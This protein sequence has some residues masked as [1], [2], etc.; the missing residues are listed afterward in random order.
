MSFNR[1][2][3]SIN[4]LRW[5]IDNRKTLLQ[6]CRI[7]EV[8][9][10]Y[11][12]VCK[13]NDSGKELYPEFLKLLDVFHGKDGVVKTQVDDLLS[14]DIQ[15][16]QD[17]L[18]FTKEQQNK[19]I[20]DARGK[21]HVKSL[22]ALI[23]EAKINL[24]LWNIDRHVVN[25]WDVTNAEGEIYQ[26]WQIKAWLSKREE[27]EAAINFEQ[28]YK[29]LLASHKPYQYKP[30]KYG[31][32][33]NNLLEINIFDLHLG[34]LCWSEEVEN[35]YDTNIA[36]ARF[37]YALQQIIHRA[38]AFDYERILFPIGN[39]FFNSDGHLN[40]TTMGTRQ[41]E[42][43]RWQ[44]TYMTGKKL[45][46][47]AIDY[48]REFAPV[49]IVV[50]PGNHDWT[51]SFF[52][53]DTLASWYRDDKSVTVN[54][55]SNPRKYYEYGNVLLGFTHGNN[56]KIESLRSLMA[57]ESREAWARTRY[58]E[59]HLGHQHRKLSVKHTI[60]SDLLHEELGV[61]IRS[62]SSLAGTDQWHH[63]QGYVGPTRAAEAFLWNKE[64]GLIGN[65]N[66]NIKLNDDK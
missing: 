18:K 36:S 8:S 26:N 40:Q 21:S 61:V 60:K 44:K 41:D 9:E 28:F 45:L 35:N 48:M 3:K 51:K 38:K 16:T 23:S 4:I 14:K 32:R 49:D 66:V 50:I 15:V 11:V 56:E 30:I 20:L 12:R 13:K 5:A 37:N 34:K 64:T 47:E 54:N 17:Y 19:G 39:D 29:D 7:F 62:M 1:L 63:Q 57:Y 27:I 22:D 31:K 59:F 10:A 2:E 43:S 24:N 33:E 55:K 52:L 6:A 42:D 65:F 46:I 53:G 58:K 25:K